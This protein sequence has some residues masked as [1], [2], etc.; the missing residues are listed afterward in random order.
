MSARAS[1]HYAVVAAA[2]EIDA[3]DAELVLQKDERDLALQQASNMLAE[4]SERCDA[5]ASASESAREAYDRAVAQRDEPDAEG[6]GAP[7]PRP[8]ALES[9]GRPSCAEARARACEE[10]PDEWAAW[11]EWLGKLDAVR[12]AMR[13]GRA[14]EAR[15]LDTAAA[16]LPSS[17]YVVPAVL[18][19]SA[20]DETVFCPSH[21]TVPR[22]PPTAPEVEET[23]KFLRAH[24]DR[25]AARYMDDPKRSFELEEDVATAQAFMHDL[26]RLIRPFSSANPAAPPAAPGFSNAVACFA[27]DARVSLF[28]EHH[29]ANAAFADPDAVAWD[30]IETAACNHFAAARADHAAKVAAAHAL[31]RDDSTGVAVYNAEAH[32]T[33]QAAD[34]IA[35]SPVADDALRACRLRLRPTEWCAPTDGSEPK[36]SRLPFVVT[37]PHARGFDV[38]GDLVAMC[39][40]LHSEEIRS[41]LNYVGVHTV[42]TPVNTEQAATLDD[43][44]DVNGRD[45]TAFDTPPT[46]VIFRGRQAAKRGLAAEWFSS[47]V[48]DAAGERVW[49]SATSG[50][51]YALRAST[52]PSDEPAELD[53]DDELAYCEGVGAAVP[54]EPL[55]KLQ[56]APAS[57]AA[58]ASYVNSSFPLARCGNAVIGSGGDNSL[59]VWDV[60]AVVAEYAE[61]TEGGGGGGGGGGAAKR[62]RGPSQRCAGFAGSAGDV[63]LIRFCSIRSFFL[64][65]NSARLRHGPV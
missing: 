36:R 43:L 18:L 57:V 56:S 8:T 46:Q 62:H 54:A 3:A 42:V 11:S 20:G 65:G 41:S 30:T 21:F 26:M 14:E 15:A 38:D 45:V 40:D 63:F 28:E 39:G 7:A 12:A 59:S 35:E 22:A 32:F 34:A 49:A 58:Q 2:E 4:A 25:T 52:A 19:G 9:G 47:V 48:A 5:A 13:A 27:I 29:V 33:F 64:L 16:S 53:D 23:L 61:E 17:G 6:A 10:H 55:A 60:A 51:I 37:M 1:D 50:S 44:V 24:P 31:P